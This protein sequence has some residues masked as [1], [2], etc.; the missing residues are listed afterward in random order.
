M[1][2]KIC[3][4]EL[5]ANKLVVL[6]KYEIGGWSHSDILGHADDLESQC[7]NAGFQGKKDE[8]LFISKY[9]HSKACLIIGLG[10][11]DERMDGTLS[12]E[13]L[14]GKL[15]TVLSRLQF[16]SVDIA[17]D[18]GPVSFA[19][20][21]HGMHLKSWAFDA[22]KTKDARRF[23]KP[24]LQNVCFMTKDV[25]AFDEQFHKLDAIAQGSFTIRDVISQPPNVM[26]P[27]ALAM[28][29]KELEKLGVKVTLLSKKE[30]HKL[31]CHALL[32]VAQGS[33]YDPYMVVLHWEGSKSDPIAVV[34]KGVTFDT[35]GISIKPSA[36]MDKMK[37]DMSGSAV[38]MGLMKTLALRKSKANVY[39]IMGLVENMPS[40]TAQR[41]GDIVTSMSGQT[42]EILNTDAEGRLVLADCLW[43]AKEKLNPT[44]IIDLATLTGAIVVCLADEY[45]GLFTNDKELCENLRK[46]GDETGE[47]LWPMP[48]SSYYDK[49]VDSDVADLKNIGGGEG[50]GSI[51]AAQ[52][53]QRFV[54]DIPWAHLDIAGV[55]FRKGDRPLHGKGASGFG[56]RLLN[57]Y[58]MDHFEK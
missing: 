5:S 50:G 8:T 26:Y 21:A 57:K 15:Y 2:L 35:G 13:E 37:T 16:E 11:K 36:N 28:K 46:A 39:G 53:L 42:I 45:A 51:T 40:G 48:L 3:A 41:P 25:Q 49:M 27:E 22:Y 30:L 58:I 14:G 1:V 10:N 6:G 55:A 24:V 52:F 32:G 44:K 47:L 9:D 38:V 54:G 56:L 4:A 19:H 43:Y 17:L 23:K 29:A 31:G 34:G 20:V 7:V 12:Y 33:Q 18:L